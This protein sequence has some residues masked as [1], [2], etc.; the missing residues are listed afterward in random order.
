MG[1]PVCVAL[2]L[3]V[4]VA[5]GALAGPAPA[6]RVATFSIVGYDPETGDLGVAVQ[7]RFFAVGTVVPWARAGVGAVATQSLANTT[8][9]PRGLDL[10]A[11]GTAP[12][13]VIATLVGEDPQRAD[14]QVGIV[15]ATGRAATFTGD[16]CLA[17]AGGR[18]GA[19]YAAQ[20][21]ILAGPQV[22][23]AMAAAYE[24]AGGDLATRLVSALAAGQAAGGDARGRQSAAVLVVREGGGYG[25]YN[26]RYVDLRVDD[27]PTPVRELQRLLALRQ[28][29]IERGRAGRLLREAGRAREADPE[30]DP[31]ADRAEGQ[32][33]EA[34]AAAER[35]VA[36]DP[37]GESGW[38]L[39]ARVRLE[40]GDRSGAAAAGRNALVA[41]PWLKTAL[42]DGLY[43][44]AELLER[45]LDIDEFR[46]LWEAIPSRR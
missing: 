12:D 30:A 23:D 18:T 24:S 36:L 34:L 10:L 4:V 3:A 21:N 45:L 6:E 40:L 13:E 7:S 11:A 46:T 15:D 19:H 39:L 22:V 37:D 32:L 41:N 35:A 5:L 29:R 8:Y 14:R 33:R 2:A 25:G 44:Q 38:F 9:G 28:A 1:R 31:E 42:L 26:D 27:H 17:W 16:S 43:G 20:G